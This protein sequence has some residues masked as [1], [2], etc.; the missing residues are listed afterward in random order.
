MDLNKYVSGDYLKASDLKDN[1]RW[2]VVSAEEVEL[3]GVKK[4]QLNFECKDL[5]KAFTLN[6]TNIKRLAEVFGTSES[7]KMVGKV[8]ALKVVETEYKGK[9]AEGIRVDVEATK[10]IEQ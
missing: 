10:K 3:D 8:L 5:K 9:P 7:D 2:V 6:Q 4:A 1:D